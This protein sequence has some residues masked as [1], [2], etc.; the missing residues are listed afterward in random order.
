MG[1][2]V[3]YL[4]TGDYNEFPSTERHPHGCA[5]GHM[6]VHRDA[7]ALEMPSLEQLTAEKFE[8]ACESLC[9]NGGEVAEL[10]IFL[11]QQ[12]EHESGL[13]AGPPGAIFRSLFEKVAKKHVVELMTDSRYE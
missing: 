6:L 4:Y 11:Y 2:I 8:Q 3:E 9:S 13:L 1:R 5:I 7:L 12:C 10:A